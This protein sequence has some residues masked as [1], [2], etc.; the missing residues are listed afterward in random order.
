MQ[1]RT[2][3]GRREFQNKVASPMTKATTESDTLQLS[4]A[5]EVLVL[6]GVLDSMSPQN[7][8]LSNIHFDPN[9]S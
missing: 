6:L 9:A 4:P 2:E 7:A 8:P 1:V 5:P 3:I